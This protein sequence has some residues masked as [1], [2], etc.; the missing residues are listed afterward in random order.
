MSN[1][2]LSTTYCHIKSQKEFIIQSKIPEIT[3]LCPVCE[4]VELLCNAVKKSYSSFNLLSKC[5]ETIPKICCELFS[6]DCAYGNCADCPSIDLEGLGDVESVSFYSWIQGKKYYSKQLKELPSIGVRKLTDIFVNLKLHYFTKKRQSKEYKT[7]IETLQLG[8]VT[9]H[10][11]YSE[12]YK[13]KQ[14]NKIKSAF[15]GQGRFT[16]YT[17]CIYV[18]ADGDAK[19]ALIT[20]ANDHSYNVTFAFPDKRTSKSLSYIYYQVLV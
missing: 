10:T 1:L 2:K 7:Q 3:C 16:I 18:N 12:N 19:Y 4:S 15:Y 20:L 5:H 9:I 17:T 13:N 14:Q 8:E 6:G 11:D